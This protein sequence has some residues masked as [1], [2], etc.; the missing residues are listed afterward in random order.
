MSRTRSLLFALKAILC[1]LA[2]SCG[3]S[4]VDGGSVAANSPV[5]EATWSLAN[6]PAEH[7]ADFSTISDELGWTPL[8]ADPPFEYDPED[9]VVE[10]FARIGE[11]ALRIHYYASEQ[12]ER[13]LSFIQGPEGYLIEV[14]PPTTESTVGRFDVKLSLAGPNVVATF[15]VGTS[16]SGTVVLASVIGSTKEEVLRFISSLHP[17]T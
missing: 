12:D 17:L 9:A 8:I 11:P 10:T 7:V 14:G 4:A 5:P 15:Q 6:G 1:V 16:R 2:L 13:G 3:R